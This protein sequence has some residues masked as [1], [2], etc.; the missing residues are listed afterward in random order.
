[1]KFNE[2]KELKDLGVAIEIKAAKEMVTRTN[3]MINH[4]LLGEIKSH[5]RNYIHNNSGATKKLVSKV[6]KGIDD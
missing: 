6:F 4:D 3:Q 1:V 2:A 5:S